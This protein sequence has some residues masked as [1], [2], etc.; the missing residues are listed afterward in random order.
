M[1]CHRVDIEQPY[2]SAA[3]SAIWREAMVPKLLREKGR[4]GVGRRVLGG[5]P[6]L[7]RKRATK[8]G[9]PPAHRMR[10]AVYRMAGV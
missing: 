6:P 5:A 3:D 7:K 9:A 1:C 4:D 10:N 8:R 2:G